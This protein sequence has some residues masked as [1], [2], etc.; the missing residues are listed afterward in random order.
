MPAWAFSIIGTSTIDVAEENREDRLP[1]VHA[2]ADERGGQHVGG[3]AGRHRNPERGEIPPAPGRR[4]GGTGARS[5][6]NSGLAASNRRCSAVSSRFTVPRARTEYISRTLG[7]SRG[8][9]RRICLH[10]HLLFCCQSA[11]SEGIGL[12]CNGLRLPSGN[13]VRTALEAA[14]QTPSASV[15]LHSAIVAQTATNSLISDYKRFDN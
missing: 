2:A 4:S 13:E 8:C 12:C 14:S 6:L 11:L 1:P 3:D 15:C 10:M 7:K 5:S 9:T